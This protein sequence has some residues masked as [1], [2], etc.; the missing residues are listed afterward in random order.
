MK[1]VKDIQ[2]S[3]RIKSLDTN[4]KGNYW[5]HDKTTIKSINKRNIA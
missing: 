1:L 4:S 2:I 5:Q 3:G